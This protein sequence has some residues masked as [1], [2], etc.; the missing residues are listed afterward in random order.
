MHFTQ[1]IEF[2][3]RKL[4]ITETENVQF[5]EMVGGIFDILEA[6]EMLVVRHTNFTGLLQAQSVTSRKFLST[7]QTLKTTSTQI[8]SGSSQVVSSSSSSSYQLK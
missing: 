1:Q 5:R 4:T 6:W 7:M 8:L 2:L 3:S